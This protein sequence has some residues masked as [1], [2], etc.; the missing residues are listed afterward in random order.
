MFTVLNSR[1]I[2]VPRH[3]EI[4]SVQYLEPLDIIIISYRACLCQKVRTL[5]MLTE[6][7]YKSLRCKLAPFSMSGNDTGWLLACFPDR[8]CI[9]MTI[10]KF[11]KCNGGT[12][13]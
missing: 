12:V 5:P 8:M 6:G 3:T 10:F 2:N 13:E 7:Q 9:L 1:I 11:Y 4:S